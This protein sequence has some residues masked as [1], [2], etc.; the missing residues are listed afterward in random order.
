MICRRG[1][2]GAELSALWA[3][4]TLV[5]VSVRVWIL[6]RRAAFDG[7]C[8]WGAGAGEWSSVE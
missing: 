6:E 7:L 4:S 5:C 8:L 3:Q 2:V 1:L